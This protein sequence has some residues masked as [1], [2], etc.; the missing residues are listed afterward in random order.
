MEAPHLTEDE[1]AEIK[2]DVS[3]RLLPNLSYKKT[4]LSDK[5]RCVDNTDR[6]VALLTLL[7]DPVKCRKY[8]A[9]PSLCPHY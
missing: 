8:P 1:M 2:K 9:T 3:M 4:Y 6:F 5:V 7:F